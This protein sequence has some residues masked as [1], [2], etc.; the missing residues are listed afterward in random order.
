[1]RYHKYKKSWEYS[2]PSSW[3]S[4][5][6]GSIPPK[7]V[8]VLVLS[9]VDPANIS[10]WSFFWPSNFLFAFPN[11]PTNNKMHECD[12]LTS[13][14]HLQ[15]EHMKVI[16]YEIHVNNLLIS[17]VDHTNHWTYVWK[18]GMLPK[19]SEKYSKLRFISA[20]M[21][22]QWPWQTGLIITIYLLKTSRSSK[23]K[24]G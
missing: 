5:E 22:E 1:M 16:L 12:C 6:T 4:H 19:N 21:E 3:G 8:R 18:A 2:W 13:N 24:L 23:A 9:T 15:S 11:K 14:F 7:L 17:T 20:W 10:P